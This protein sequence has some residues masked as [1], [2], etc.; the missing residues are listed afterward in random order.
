MKTAKNGVFL[1]EIEWNYALGAHFHATSVKVMRG[2][3]DTDQK[4]GKNWCGGVCFAQWLAFYLIWNFRNLFNFLSNHKNKQ[5][6]WNWVFFVCFQC[7]TENEQFYGN[8]VH[9][10]WPGMG[11]TRPDMVARRS[12]WRVSTSGRTHGEH[13]KEAAGSRT[14]LSRGY[15]V[16]L[17]ELCRRFCCLKLSFFALNLPVNM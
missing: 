11:E 4:Y 12:L 17:S 10:W 13:E 14:I 7:K 9:G 1:G 2:E 6:Y 16:S 5:L 8:H 3:L 15:F